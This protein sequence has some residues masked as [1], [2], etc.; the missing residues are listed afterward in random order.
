MKAIKSFKVML[1][2]FIFAMIA[3]GLSAIIIT[4][5]IIVG[6]GVNQAGFVVVCEN[7][8]ACFCALH[9]VYVYIE[10]NQI[11]RLASVST[12]DGDLKDLREFLRKGAPNQP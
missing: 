10:F 12:S 9:F 4:I 1:A 8:I 11:Q 2:I 6:L 5:F 7:I 3:E